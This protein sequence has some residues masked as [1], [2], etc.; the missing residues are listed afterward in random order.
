VRFS[1]VMYVERDLLNHVRNIRVSE[2]Q[3]LQSAGQA[4][5]MCRVVDRIAHVTREL[6]RGVDWS[7]ARFVVN[8][9]VLPLTQE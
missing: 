1:R 7:G 6:R 3:V 8:H 2:C 5:V 4:A 9:C